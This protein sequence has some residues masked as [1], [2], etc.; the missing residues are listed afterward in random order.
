MLTDKER[1][2]IQDRLELAKWRT[3]TDAAKRHYGY[4]RKTPVMGVDIP[5]FSTTDA[6]NDLESRGK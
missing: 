4:E 5:S 2:M 1:Q 3:L 6:I